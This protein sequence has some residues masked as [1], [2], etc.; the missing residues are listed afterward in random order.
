MTTSESE[1]LLERAR[2]GELTAAE[3][4]VEKVRLQRVH[5]VIGRLSA[6]VRGQLR[7]AV[8]GGALRHVPR[9]G[10]LPEAY[11]HP[12]FEYL[13]A[14]ARNAHAQ[15]AAVALSRVFA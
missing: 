15:R 7:A 11:Y 4:N 3:Y 10:L 2:R 5:I 8:N 6:E 13:V 1:H 14:A 12:S 9:S